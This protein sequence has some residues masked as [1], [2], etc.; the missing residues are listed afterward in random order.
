MW[1]FSEQDRGL[2]VPGAREPRASTGICSTAIVQ[3]ISLEFI[4]AYNRYTPIVS[5]LEL[6][7][8]WH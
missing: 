7:S 8:F 3:Y 1:P 4:H 6:E 2:A 5:K